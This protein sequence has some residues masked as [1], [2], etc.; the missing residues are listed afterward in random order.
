M[1]AQLSFNLDL[2]EEKKD[3]EAA[4][5]GAEWRGVF[6]DLNEWLGELEGRGDSVRPERVKEALALMA[7]KRGL[8]VFD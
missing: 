5:K 2:D 7:K 6:D 8:S 3:F 1:K 4:L